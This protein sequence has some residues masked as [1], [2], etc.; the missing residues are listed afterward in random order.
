MDAG[1]I[2]I[3]GGVVAT[4]GVLLSILKFIL[5]SIDSRIEEKAEE[6][7]E[8]AMKSVEKKLTVIETKLDNGVMAEVKKTSE[9][10][11]R[12]DISLA[13]LSTNV[14]NLTRQIEEEHHERR[15]G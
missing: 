3:L 1:H 10:V 14:I 4:I 12:L 9:S 15:L 13:S 8:R 7:V 5:I 11:Q 2:A 6:C